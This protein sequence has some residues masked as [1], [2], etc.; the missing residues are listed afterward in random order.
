MN[1]DTRLLIYVLMCLLG[2]I[3]V[4]YIQVEYSR[5]AYEAGDK[6]AYAWMG[7]FP[8]L[9]PIFVI[10]SAKYVASFAAILELVIFIVKFWSKN[11]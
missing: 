9:V 6:S 5:Q 8:F 1:L 4:G 11:E 3:L 2:T 7:F 10:E